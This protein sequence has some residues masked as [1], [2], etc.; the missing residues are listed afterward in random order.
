M[1]N[2]NNFG[3]NQMGFNPMPINNMGMIGMN[4]IQ[5]LN[6]ENAL[7]IKYIIQPYENK[8]KELEEIIRQKDFQIA[9]LKDKL[10]SNGMN[11]NIMNLIL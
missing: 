6:D 4:N 10:N 2:M 3:I 7:R 5:N 9:V 11:L 8:I 1:N